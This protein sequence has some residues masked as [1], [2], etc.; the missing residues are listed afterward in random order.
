MVKRFLKHHTAYQRFPM[1]VNSTKPCVKKKKK[2][3][4]LTKILDLGE[5]LFLPQNVSLFHK[6]TK[7][8]RNPFW[9]DW[10]MIISASESTV[11]SLLFFCAPFF[12]VFFTWLQHPVNLCIKFMKCLNPS[13]SLKIP[14]KVHI[15][16]TYK[17]CCLNF[18]FL[19]R[20]N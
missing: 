8:L 11:N 9:G 17:F 3:L 7:T 1:R 13:D 18:A 2:N 6:N 10:H 5:L 14:Q 4:S 19:H 15:I 20:Y 16:F 12:P